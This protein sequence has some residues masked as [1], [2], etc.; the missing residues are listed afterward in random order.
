MG[1]SY[2]KSLLGEREEAILIAHQHWFLLA[3]DIS[4]EVALIILSIVLVTMIWAGLF[5]PMAALG[6]LLIIL[7]IISLLRDILRWTSHKYV[8]TSRRVIQLMGV[9]NKNV[10][11]SSLEKVNDVKME[12]SFWGRLFGFGDV[13]IL[14]ASELGVNR[15]TMIG[16]PVRFKTAMLNAKGRLELEQA[17]SAGGGEKTIPVLIEQMDMLRK[18][19]VLTEEEFQKKKAE[20]LAK[21]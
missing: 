16:D 19:N 4:P 17:A 3:R 12:Q 6:Y 13:E 9:F 20:L 11:D 15:F 8:V 2:L 21:M 10:I 14:T 5:I 7:P 18:E 1:D